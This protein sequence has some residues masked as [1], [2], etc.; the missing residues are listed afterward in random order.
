MHGA[1][2][3]TLLAG[4]QPN[5][6]SVKHACECLVA[7][8]GGRGAQRVLVHDTCHGVQCHEERIVA[9]TDDRIAKQSIV[10]LGAMLLSLLQP[11][12]SRIVGITIDVEGNIQSGGAAAKSVL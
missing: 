6:S 8:Q 2:N 10:T 3:E 11:C 9:K 7:A 4:P 12:D 1:A 5:S